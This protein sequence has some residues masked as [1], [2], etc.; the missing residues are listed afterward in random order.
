MAGSKEY[1]MK[2]S[3]GVHPVLDVPDQIPPA[4]MFS[5]LDFDPRLKYRDILNQMSQALKERNMEPAAATTPQLM[6][7]GLL[8]AAWDLVF[9]SIPGDKMALLYHDAGSEVSGEA[10]DQRAKTPARTYAVMIKSTESAGRKWV[11][12]RATFFEDRPVC[13]CEPVEVEKGKTIDV[14]LTVK[15]MID[16]E[17]MS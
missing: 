10:A 7:Q 11:V 4:V 3:W 6:K 12:T 17:T 5:I 1:F 9:H 14:R 15:K 16:L 13:W 8:I 2:E